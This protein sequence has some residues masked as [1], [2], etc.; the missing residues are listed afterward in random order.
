MSRV[1]IVGSEGQIGTQL[2]KALSNRDDFDYL[3]LCDIK[4]KSRT[5]LNY[6]K[7]DALSYDDLK[8]FIIDK[9][10]NEVYHLAAILSA[11]GEKDPMRTWNLNMN[12]LFNILKLAKEGIIE[13]V[14][15]PSSI[16]VFGNN[17]PKNDTPQFSNKEPITSYGISKLAGESWC[18][19]F[20]TTYGTDIRSIR[21]PGVISYDALPGGGTTDYAVDIF[22]S[23]KS[24]KRYTCFL[25]KDTILPMIYID[26]AIDGIIKLMRA[27]KKKLRIQSSYNLSA[28]SMSPKMIEEEL[29]K[30]DNGFQ[31]DYVPDYR[32]AIADSWPNTIDDIYAC[33]DW[34]WNSK[35]NFKETTNH[36]LSKLAIL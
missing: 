22:H 25:D 27:P 29:K 15:W 18:K 34:D 12:S 30:I 26:D 3:F 35:Y 16:A 21:F 1:L 31:V 6:F 19:Y 7:V 32:Q 20:N 24:K 13:K 23:F 2:S 8:S 14:F 4:D 11:K 33:E 5:D 9:K 28:F 17:N 36:M 10:I